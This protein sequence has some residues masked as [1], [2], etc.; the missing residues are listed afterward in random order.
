MENKNNW[1]VI[2]GEIVE[3]LKEAEHYHS[4]NTD[5]TCFLSAYQ[6]AVLLYKKNKTLIKNSSCPK[7]IGGKGEGE[8]NSLSQY[9][10]N[11]LSKDI[12]NGP[13]TGIVSHEFLNIS[14]LEQF[15]FLDEKKI[16]SQPSNICF[17]M[18]RYLVQ[19]SCC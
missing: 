2:R 3:I 5:K 9:I 14:G 4:E 10:A 19:N 13:L 8:Y 6:L 17:S 1:E 16:I 11:S 7:N 12:K 15:S 18:F